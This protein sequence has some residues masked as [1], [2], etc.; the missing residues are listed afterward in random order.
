MWLRRLHRCP[1]GGEC[2]GRISGNRPG[3]ADGLL[4]DPIASYGVPGI[5]VTGVWLSD[6]TGAAGSQLNFSVTTDVN[7]NAF[8]SNGRVNAYWSSAIG[9]NIPV[10]ATS[11]GTFYVD[12]DVGIPWVCPTAEVSESQNSSTNFVLPAGAP[13]RITSYGD[14]TT[15]HGQPELR[16]YI[17]AASPGLVSTFRATSTVEG[18]ST[19]F[20]FPTQS[21][22]SAL[23]EGFYSLVNT[24]INSDGT[25]A[26]VNASYLAVGGTTALSSAFGVDAAD[27]IST[28]CVVVSG[29][30]R[31]SPTVTT[32]APILTQYYS[33]EVSYR[34]T[35]IAVGS[36]PVAVRL[37]GS[38]SW[39][40][41]GGDTTTVGP[42]NAIVANSGSSSV[43]ILDLETSSDVKNISVGSQ[44]MSLTLNSADTMAYVVS[45]G[46]GSLAEIDLSTETV[47][48]TVNGLTGA[49]SVAM[50]PG[51]SYVWV[52]GT[53]AI[54]KVSLS[55]Y[56]VVA[57]VSV[58]GSV[59]SLAASS[60]QNE[61]V[62][63]LVEDCCIASSTYAA[64]ELL[65]S[66]LSRPG[67]YASGTASPF[68]DY[69]MKG[70]LPTAAALPQ[71]SNVVS[72]R[73][74]NG[75]AVSSTPTGFVIYD[76]VTHEQI[77]TGATPTPV[78]GIACDPDAM[79]AYFTLPDSNEYISVP[80][81]YAP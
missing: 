17:G 47:T 28:T 9:W 43:S 73:F 74:S 27:L 12:P 66:N 52:G 4:G 67:S 14:F 80:L 18:S 62:Y 30:P 8:V 36:E 16:V 37:Y 32:A 60:A 59:T 10:C 20:P 40:S 31:C 5:A 41:D 61:L 11:S 51:G 58:S 50:D 19:T 49:L 71:A 29:K 44:P 46:S 48:H 7:G 63:T 64:N 68:A 25:L 26:F 70:T 72:A 33:G 77:M 13:S 42:A 21:S 65:L 79:Y 55:T 78:R 1:R 75:M 24:N 69:T 53:N 34:G 2:W 22:G 39:T 15:A 35:T 23:T 54:Y 38:Y 56:A 81:E 76:L 6:G 57:T 45:Y 3:A